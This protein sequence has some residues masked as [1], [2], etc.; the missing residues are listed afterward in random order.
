MSKL[1]FIP[2]KNLRAKMSSN[3]PEKLM[4]NQKFQHNLKQFSPALCHR[5]QCFHSY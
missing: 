3:F 4:K 1:N 2:M 5:V